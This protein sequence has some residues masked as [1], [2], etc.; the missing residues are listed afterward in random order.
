MMIDIPH[1][2]PTLGTEESCAAA[3]VLESGWVAQGKEVE[4]LEDEFC[5]FLGLPAGHAVA[6]S[7]GTAAL[8]LALWVLDARGKKILFPAYCCS[9]LRHAT[10][11]AGGH[12]VIADIADGSPN[13]DVKA[14]NSITADIAI[15]AHMY[16]LPAD[17]SVVKI[18]VIED[19]AQALGASV[20]GAP[21]G[22]RGEIGI[23]SFYATKLITSGGQ[24]GMI[25][26]KTRTLADAVRDYRQFDCRRD[27]KARFNF[28][29]TDLQAAIG[30]VQLSRL[31]GFLDARA[32]I[33][34]KYRRSGMELLD[35]PSRGPQRLSP[36][37]YRAVLKTESP[38]RTLKS[39]EEVGIGAIVPINDWELLGR[40]DSLP[41]ALGLTRMTVSLPIYPSL[42]DEAVER[43]IAAIGKN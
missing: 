13:I 28:Q 1:N 12:E 40:P 16:G 15:I 18:P 42:P 14:I 10:A 39:L 33:F 30:R 25:V 20:D 6:L 7:S 32:R 5:A 37:R 3:R 21:V 11:M 43:V 29:M 22:L 9:A 36:A 38:E 35:V 23:F 4:A 27:A 17:V 2:R 41:K 24:G 34:D 31:P 8:F 19:C 26:S